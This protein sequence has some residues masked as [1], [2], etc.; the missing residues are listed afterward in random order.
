MITKL[1]LMG[2]LNYIITFRKTVWINRFVAI[3]CYERIG[4]ISSA[5]IVKKY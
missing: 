3:S 1:L 2:M 4:K 5:E